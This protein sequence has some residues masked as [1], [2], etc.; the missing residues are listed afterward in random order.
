[1]KIEFLRHLDD[2]GGSWEVEVFERDGDD[3]ISGLISNPSGACYPIIDG[4]P[5]LL[6]GV[7]LERSLAQHSD[8]TTRHGSRFAGIARQSVASNGDALKLKTIKN[9]SYQWKRFNRML[10]IYEMNHRLYFHP[11]GEEFFR[12]RL[13]LDAG[14]GTGRHVYY[15]AK[16]G[17]EMVAID[18]SDAVEVAYHNTRSMKNVHVAQADI[19]DLPFKKDHFDFVESVGV[20]HILPDPRAALQGLL[21]FLR[22]AGEMFIYVYS[23]NS[24]VPRDRKHAVKLFFR[25]LYERIGRMLPRKT[26][27]AYCYIAAALGRT[28]NVPMRMLKRW[29]PTRR[30]GEVLSVFKT[31]E[32]YPFYVLHTDLFDWIGTPLNRYYTVEEVQSLFTGGPLDRVEIREED[33]QWRVFARKAATSDAG[34]NLDPVFAGAF[35][36]TGQEVQPAESAR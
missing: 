32:I 7:W 8:F 35:A 1:M 28:W 21:Q 33:P 23:A 14:C 16:Y 25:H 26:L 13:G 12:G 30:V 18:L 15:A 29:G 27:V 10:A 24:V 22:V 2:A 11:R 17:A 36:S 31:Y 34:L 3:I 4:I 5:R 9:F 19:Y 6:K 20:I